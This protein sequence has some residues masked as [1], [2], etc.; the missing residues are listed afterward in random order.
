MRGTFKRCKVYLEA[1]C[2]HFKT[3]TKSRYV[4][5]PFEKWTLKFPADFFKCVV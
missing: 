1:G 2:Q 5:M 4:E 3:A